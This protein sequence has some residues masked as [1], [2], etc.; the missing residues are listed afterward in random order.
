MLP[1]QPSSS[2]QPA[3]PQPVKV[4]TEVALI[5]NSMSM[6]NNHINVNNPD[7][8]YL[9]GGST[10]NQHQRQMNNSACLSSEGGG[11]M[12]TQLPEELEQYFNMGTPTPFRMEVYQEGF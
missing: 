6:T 11:G 12:G 7:L 4:P 8:N 5:N 10:S 9:T 1:K 2:S 3:Y